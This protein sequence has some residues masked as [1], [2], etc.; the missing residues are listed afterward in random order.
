MYRFS[1]W[2]I[3]LLFLHGCISFRVL[4]AVMNNFAMLEQSDYRIQA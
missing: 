3:F 2:F 4:F 1:Q